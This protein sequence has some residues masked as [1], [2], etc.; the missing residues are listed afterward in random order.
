MAPRPRLPP[1]VAKAVRRGGSLPGGISAKVAHQ[2]KSLRGMANPRRRPVTAAK[3]PLPPQG[4]HVS[5][6]CVR[7]NS[8]GIL[9]GKLFAHWAKKMPG[10]PVTVDAV[11]YKSTDFSARLRQADLM[12]PVLGEKN[13]GFREWTNGERI[14]AAED[15]SELRRRL[16]EWYKEPW[17]QNGR[18]FRNGPVLENYRISAL[19]ESIEKWVRESF[20]LPGGKFTPGAGVGC[21]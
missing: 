6:Y 2:A 20:N 10:F 11:G 3:K 15:A 14:L 18:H 7:G 1:R 19:A 5:I 12:I 16:F 17:A 21:L 8:S 4:L 13:F 9:A